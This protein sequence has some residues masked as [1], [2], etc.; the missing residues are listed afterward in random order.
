MKKFSRTLFFS[1]SALLIH[2]SG[3]N[4]STRLQDLS[5]IAENA[6]LI[7][8]CLPPSQAPQENPATRSVRFEGLVFR[9]AR[10]NDPFRSVRVS[11]ILPGNQQMP[12]LRGGHVTQN[13]EASL[14]EDTLDLT[15]IRLWRQAQ[16]P[17][18]PPPAC[19]LYVAT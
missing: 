15:F 4:A 19:F 13:T 2:V 8:F 3:A 10:V 7:A 18:T 14:L 11:G 5:N 6:A 12:V 1:L 16:I 9:S 17:N